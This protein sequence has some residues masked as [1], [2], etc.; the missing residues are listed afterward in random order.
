MARGKMHDILPQGREEMCS[1]GKNRPKMWNLILFSHSVTSR[2]IVCNKSS[3]VSVVSY[4]YLM[5]SL[6]AKILV[7]VMHVVVGFPVQLLITRPLISISNL[8]FV[9]SSLLFSEEKQIGALPVQ[10]LFMAVAPPLASGSRVICLLA[11]MQAVLA[12]HAQVPQL[13]PF[14]STAQYPLGCLQNQ[15]SL[16]FR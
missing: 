8:I 10:G 3:G 5:L 9:L 14:S 16:A 13:F 4:K 15:R 2:M 7:S 12:D 11:K 6:P 1:A